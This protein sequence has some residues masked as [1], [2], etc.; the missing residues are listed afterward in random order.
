[1]STATLPVIDLDLFLGESSQSDAVIQECRK[2]F[3][4]CIHCSGSHAHIGT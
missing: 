4:A 1:M 3:S 2:V